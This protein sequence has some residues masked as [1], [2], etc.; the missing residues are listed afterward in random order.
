MVGRGTI[1][2][3]KDKV[4]YDYVVKHYPDEGSEFGIENEGRISK[5]TIR[6]HGETKALVN[7]DRGWDIPVPDD[8]DIKAAYAILLEKYN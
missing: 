2:I 1:W 8:K 5:L 6:K 7:Y 4:G 3:V